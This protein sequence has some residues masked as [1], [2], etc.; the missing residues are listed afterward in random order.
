MASVI[1]IK[2]SGVSGSPVTLGQAE[3]AYSYFPG[4]ESNGGDRLYIGTGTETNG[5]AANIEVIGGK[6]FTQKLDHTPGVTTA[7]SAVIVDMNR[8]TDFLKMGTISVANNTIATTATEIKFAGAK[9]TGVA[10]PTANSDV[11]NL[12]YLNNNFTSVLSMTGDVGS[13]GVELRLD[14]LDFR[15][16]GGISMSVANNNVTATLV[17]TGVTAATYGD[18]V[19]VPKFTVNAQGRITNV[20][21]TTV[22]I[23]LGTHT[24]GDYVKTLAVTA[25]NGLIIDTGTGAGST[26]TLSAVI[27]NTTH[28][29]VSSY[30]T[31]DFDVSLAGK[32]NLKDTVLK[33]VTTDS[34]TLLPVNHALS[35]LGGEGMDVTHSGTTIT[36][37]GEIATYTNLGVASFSS[38]N[39]TVAGGAVSTNAATLGTSTLNN[40]TTTVNL[41]GLQLL[42]VDNIRVDGNTISTTNTNGDLILQT[43][44]TGK[45]N[46]SNKQIV[47]VPMPIND[48]DAANKR[49]VDEIAQG[50]SVKPAVRVATTGNLAGTYANGTNGV[51]ATLNLGKL[52]TLNIDG[53]STW[54]V[55]EGILVKDQT[56]PAQNGRYDVTQ[57]GSGT[58]DW[59]LTRTTSCDTKSEIPSMFIFAQEGTQN[60][61]TGWVAVV[62]STSSYTVGTDAVT[63]SQFSGAGTYLAGAGL[64]ISGNEFFV[65]VDN[66]SL[67]I[68]GDTLRN[69]ALGTTN[70]HLA[71]GITNDKITNSFVNFSVDGGA[72]D[73][74]NLGE[75]I[76]LAGGEGIDTAFGVDNTL[77]ISAELASYSNK[78]VASFDVTHFDV[79]SGAV[80]LKTEAV[81]DLVGS[82]IQAGES[83]NVTYD[84]VGNSLTIGSRIATTAAR[85]VASFSSANFGLTNGH[86]EITAMDGGTY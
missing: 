11:V 43:N 62:A 55:G 26:P 72:I 14:T 48:L 7:N 21:N 69:K 15:G 24:V 60:K 36:V 22:S 19:T 30:D 29:G 3:L 28:V 10:N 52:A 68:I 64:T 47:N 77:T 41:Q 73:K 76:T 37:A 17:D 46:A 86:V 31:A 18:A 82:F 53:I 25:N 39:F 59:I 49:Y 1:K 38:T 8:A 50:L 2:R 34:G 70:D 51:G 56:N 65:N 78:G 74:V 27:A 54:A 75:T 83:I 85:G 66:T 81:Q 6:Y 67:E 61:N 79:T 32:V 16:A 80:A 9:L 45:I 12:G 13:D 57:V 20:V 5:E 58:V 44:G 33:S 23:P 35:I 4:T 71:G 40:G 84:D 42:E 63:F